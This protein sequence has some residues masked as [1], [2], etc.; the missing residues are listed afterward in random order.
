MK[1]SPEKPDG[2]ETLEEFAKKPLETK[3]RRYKE[4]EEED[5]EEAAKEARPEAPLS[6]MT[7][8]LIFMCLES[9]AVKNPKEHI[10]TVREIM[11]FTEPQ[12]KAF[13]ELLLAKD[14]VFRHLNLSKKGLSFI[15]HIISHPDDLE[16][17]KLIEED[18]HLLQ[19]FRKWTSWFLLKAGSLG[20][21]FILGIY[22]YTSWQKYGF[23]NKIANYFQRKKTVHPTVPP[24]QNDVLR[25]VEN[26]QDHSLRKD[27]IMP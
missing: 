2:E 1:R 9:P 26:G 22:G 4:V 18:E 15:S 7:K 23:P 16:T 19:D 10:E 21:L 3:K 6:E 5:S 14:D 20:S 13:L 17:Q 8:K 11:L 27:V 25:S 24:V 12:G